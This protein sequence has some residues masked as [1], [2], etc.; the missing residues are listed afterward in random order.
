[1]QLFSFSSIQLTSFSSTAA[2]KE[3]V[4]LP[5]M[6]GLD[7]LINVSSLS[8][9]LLCFV[10]GTITPN[11]VLHVML[12]VKFFY[13]KLKLCQYI[14]SQNQMVRENVL[15]LFE[16]FESKSFDNNLNSFYIAGITYPQPSTQWFSSKSVK[17]VCS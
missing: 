14:A 2:G 10:D 13:R 8:S 12:L 17:K 1:M 16:I 5:T 15:F 11:H 9:L 3:E 6:E 4:Q 7:T